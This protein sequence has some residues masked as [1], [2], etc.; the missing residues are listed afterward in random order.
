MTD[1]STILNPEILCA[2]VDVNLRE[3]EF[4]ENH[5]LGPYFPWFWQERQTYGDEDD[6][7][8]NIKP[9]I[10]SHNGQ[11]LSHT[12]LFRTEIESTK[13]NER[14][15][16]EISPHFEFFLELFNRFMMANNL[17][18]KNIFRANLN[19]TWHNGNLHTAP[20]LDHHWPHN[21]FVMYLTSCDQGQT[22]IWPD[23]FSTS[24][25]IPCIQY[26]AVSFKQ[27]W[28]AQ[29][30]PVPGSRRLVFVLTYI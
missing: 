19:L 21:N 29:R 10:K 7:P 28:H 23:D 18:Y 12:L 17:K 3:R 27:H 2:P 4:I 6:I 30:Y 22:V 16:N 14:P 8:E 5:V 15:S 9:Y 25:L 11:F 13:Y 1:T 24:Y 20:H 26:T